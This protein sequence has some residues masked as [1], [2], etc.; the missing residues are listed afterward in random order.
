MAERFAVP[1]TAEKMGCPATTLTFLGIELV[2]MESRLLSDKL[3]VLNGLIDELLWR[4]KCKLW[5]V[6]KVLGH[7]NIACWM[8][9]PGWAFC[10]SIA[11]AMGGEVK[12]HHRI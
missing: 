1:L 7:L 12:P 10:K 2:A 4:E 11:F 6:Q 9:R 3:A 8:V 5:L